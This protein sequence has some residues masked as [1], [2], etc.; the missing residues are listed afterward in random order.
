LEF[1]ENFF[2]ILRS[3]ISLP[4]IFFV[5]FKKILIFLIQN[6]EFLES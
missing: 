4:I 2:E 1:L 3:A 6:S 5:E